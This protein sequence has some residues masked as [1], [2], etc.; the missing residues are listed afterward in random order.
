MERDAEYIAPVRGCNIF[1]FPLAGTENPGPMTERGVWSSCLL[2]TL[3]KSGIMQRRCYTR[4]SVWIIGGMIMTGK[5][6]ST[7]RKACATVTL[8][9]TTA[10]LAGRELNLDPPQWEF[11]N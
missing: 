9:T 6:Q 1:S 2:M 7:R 4:E 8:S 11:G 5:S 10:A 3:P